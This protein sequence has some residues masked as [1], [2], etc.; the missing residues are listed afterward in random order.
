MS[1]VRTFPEAIV[2]GGGLVGWAT[3]CAL[4]RLG[5]PALLIDAGDEGAATFAGAGM[6]TP[7]TNLDPPPGYLPLAIAATRHYSRLIAELAEAGCGETG[8]AT[9]GA[10]YVARDLSE[11]AG[12]DQVE[13]AL[14]LRRDA[15]MTLIGAV[16]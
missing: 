11:L 2:V 12:L 7:G 9:P 5:L 3:A 1:D 6:I 4:A 8:Y 15:G 16:E 14:N 10:I 13:R